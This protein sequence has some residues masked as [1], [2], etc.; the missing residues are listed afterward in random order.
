M[1]LNVVPTGPAEMSIYATPV[2]R[3]TLRPDGFASVHAGAGEGE[4]VTKVLRFAG[5]EL[6]VNYSTSA[7]G[8]L[9]VEIQDAD[10]KPLPGF[11]LADCREMV[12]DSI[13][14]AVSWG[15][16]PDVAALAGRAVR[17]RFVVQDGDLYAIQFRPA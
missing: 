14:Q 17:L 9:R 8:G 12:G 6:S 2:R 13:D 11:T 1:A 7:G 15:N 5:K 16:G 4:M 3:F 10:G